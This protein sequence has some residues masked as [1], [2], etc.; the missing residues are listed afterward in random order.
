ME[1]N[2]NI[3]EIE[4]FFPIILYKELNNLFFK[5]DPKWVLKE[6]VTGKNVIKPWLKNNNVRD[7]TAFT[8]VVENNTKEYE[9]IFKNVKHFIEQKSPYKVEKFGRILFGYVPPDPSYDHEKY[10]MTPHIDHDIEGDWKNFLYYLNDNDASTIFFNQVYKKNVP[11]N[12]QKQEI[13]YKIKP[14]KNKA[15]IFDRSIYHAGS[16]SNLNKRIILSIH[17]L[18]K[19]AQIC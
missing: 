1:H 15:V 11:E 7:A 13:V 17:F 2:L 16:V 14:V 19:N 10:H 3:L 12:Y 8:W 18:V 5:E 4:N 9:F 6:V